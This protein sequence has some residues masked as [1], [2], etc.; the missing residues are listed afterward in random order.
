MKPGV[1]VTFDV[2]CSMG[3]AWADN[4]LRPVPP[5]L[6]MMGRYG[7]RSYGIPLI[8]EILA[9]H[10]LCATFFVEPFNAELG[11]PGQTEPVCRYLID[12]GQDVQLHV[13]P[14]HVHYGL[15]LDGKPHARTDYMADLPA[16]RQREMLIEGAGRIVRWTGRS[17]I[18]F[19][20]GNMGASE[21]TLSVLPG[22]G[23]WIDSSYSFPFLGGQCRFGN[24]GVYNGA[25]WYGDVLEVALS[26]FFQKPIPKI[27]P[28]SQYVDL[29]GASFEECRDAVQMICD[30]G[31]DAVLILHSFS[32]F[33]VRDIQYRGGR[34]NRVVTRRFERFCHWLAENRERYPARTFSELGRMV[35]EDGYQ[36]KAVG[37]CRLN[38][39]LRALT[40][41]LVQGLNR[42]YWF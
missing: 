21:E 8:C 11:H 19:R 25:R 39:P 15:H 33:K 28:P 34:P 18:A 23:L 12:H 31:A 35:R 29:M 38:K 40:R 9:R 1:F 13:H 37:P 30:A 32:L 22:A 4:S 16:D 6:G 5:R 3:G 42:F 26:G 17:P 7:D 27:L 20:A 10:G 24:R 14:N 2:E 36:P 41:K